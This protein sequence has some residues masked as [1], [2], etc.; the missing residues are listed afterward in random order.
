M[1]IWA[2]ILI[3]STTQSYSQCPPNNFT[4]SDTVCPT[5]SLIIDNSLSTA[6]S[7]NWDFCTGDLDSIPTAVALPLIGGTLSYPINMKMIE[8][9]GNHYGFIVNSFGGNY[10]TRYDFGN[11]PANPPTATNLNSDPLLGNNTTGIDIVKEGSKW[12]MFITA[13]SANA[14]LRYEMDSI[15]QLNPTLVNLN[16]AGLSGPSSIK[17]IDDY[18][19][20]ANNSSA[21]I[22]RISFGGS[23]LNT[24]VALAPIPTGVFNNFGID[25]AFDCVTN[26]YIGYTTSSAFG[27]LSKMDF[28]NSLSNTPTFTTAASSIWTGLGLQIVKEEGNWHIFLVTENNNFYH[29]KA[30]I[31]LDQPLTLDYMTAFGGIMNNPQNVQMT[32]VGSDW[33][34]IIPNR[35]LFSIVRVQFPQGCT[36]TA[37]AYT[38]QSPTGISFAP[39]Q[40]GYN[41]FEL[42]ETNAN[43]SV[44]YFLDSVLVQVS[45][46]EANFGTSSG[47]INSPITFTDLST[48]CYGTI[49]GWHWDFGDGNS[50]TLPSPS[51]NYAST[52]TF[53]TTLKVYSSNG[54]SASVQ[55]NVTI[56]ETPVAWFTR[57][58]SACVG[59]DVV[60]TDS[61]TS[62]DGVL[63][64]WD[65][66][67]GDSDTGNG[68]T[69]SHAYLNAGVYSIE[70]ISTT[71]FGCKDTAVRT[72][73][74]NP[75][76]I[77]DFLIFNTCAGETAQ[78]LNTTTATGTS[79]LSTA[80]DFGNGNNSSQTNPNH[81]YSSTANTY[82]ISLISTAIN[83]CSDTIVKSIR[84]AN[85]PL[86]WF[87]MSTDT[88]CTFANIQL[89]DNSFAGA[90]D[91]INKRHWDF[92]DGSVDSTTLNPNHIYTSPGSYTIR[93]TVQSP[94]NCDSSIT[95][96]LFIIESPTAQFT[97]NNVC[98]G[99]TSNFMDLSTAPA[100][101]SITD[102]TWAFGDTNTSTLS[103]PTHTYADTGYYSVSLIVK[104]DIGCYD[105]ST[106]ITQVYSLPNSWF[107]FGLACTGAPVQFTDSS[108]VI[109]STVNN[110][111]WSFGASGATSAL[112]N[113]TYIY[114]DALAF[115][116]TLIATTAQGCSDTTTKIA[117]I[118]QS[119]VFTISSPDH[120]FG[121]NNQFAATPSPGST[122]SYSYLW[123]FGDSTASFLPQP[124]HTFGNQGL[125]PISLLVTDINN[126]C[127]SEL[128]DSLTVYGLPLAGFTNSNTCIGSVVNFQ[129]TSSS[130]NGNIT[131]WNWTLGNAGN[132]I[133]Q[134]P[135]TIFINSGTQNIKLVV[136]SSYGCS[137]STTKAITV[138]DLPIVSIAATPNYGAPPLS[139]QF[140][141]NSD[142]GTYDWN[143]GDGTSNS[144]AQAPV[145]IFNDTGLY[146]TNLTVVNQY[147][148]EDSRSLN[149]YVQ[150][151]RRDLSI[152]GVSFLKVNNK[153]TMKAIVANLGNEDAS[154]FE[155]KGNLSGEN[156]FYN[157]FKFDTLKAG[158]IKEYTFNTSLGAGITT[159]PYFCAE[160]ISINGQQDMNP[161]NDR[162]C[163]SSSTSFEIFNVYPNPF[164]DQIYMGVNMLRKGDI[165]LSLVNMNGSIVFENRSYTLDEGL[166]TLSIPLDQLAS[167][168]YVLKVNYLDSNQYF[169][170]VRD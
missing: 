162:F 158:T 64:Q 40:L 51:H 160:V 50:S 135:S 131:L 90:G 139:V 87:S 109:G 107:T 108:S 31:T 29:Y 72:I 11:S 157:T 4:V 89:T 42:K 57:P 142:P 122:S 112:Q 56:H 18:A 43:G 156:V 124:T 14:L 140:I 150:I 128:F 16:L 54:D 137:D 168:V 99:A 167:A 86:P 148:C 63:Q 46:P 60:L 166:N 133:L 105:T 97:I 13:S 55:Q 132:S 96:T 5:Q 114:N 130:I 32:K 67:F 79:I 85:Q 123:N 6:T 30:G 110:W 68:N 151:P 2:I 77:S 82:N 53:A 78:F 95:R 47:C 23:Y 154:E 74:I 7:F 91:S 143:F 61:S 83:G 136:T 66:K 119:P 12:Y 121:T 73:T 39:T 8:V 52:G 147:G 111:S 161:A 15:T 19:F 81:T 26:K 3:F 37:N 149:I 94:E 44:Q 76:P 34:G 129:D 117:L 127:I 84:I 22:T 153:W 92:G 59:S 58:D 134:N 104:S 88:A 125:F 24:P 164:N 120:C 38:A 17:V 93:L 45:P 159:P 144:T 69:V 100:G 28:G 1:I 21:E 102:W 9:N 35:L 80:W 33:I 49:T 98:Q 65:W 138:Y 48:I 145:H 36:G 118:N 169:R 152:N 113:P 116:V 163:R 20:I 70:L 101:S 25:V 41:T 115:P 155:L 170:I 75:G 62:N 165:I 146:Q 106:T 27:L 103:S 71:V 141:N 126:G 10:I